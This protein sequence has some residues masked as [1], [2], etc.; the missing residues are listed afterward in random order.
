M[1]EQAECSGFKYEKG[2]IVFV[3]HSDG[4][5]YVGTIEHRAILGSRY[6]PYG[7]TF[8][9]KDVEQARWCSEEELYPKERR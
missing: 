1:E 5:Y 8:M 4:A 7:V 2:T 9:V 6:K 3:K